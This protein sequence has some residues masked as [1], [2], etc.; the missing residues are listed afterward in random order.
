LVSKDTTYVDIVESSYIDV[1]CCDMYGNQTDLHQADL[2][3]QSALG[4]F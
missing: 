4:C 1:F 2:F 3:F